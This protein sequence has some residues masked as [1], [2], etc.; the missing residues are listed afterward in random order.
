[1][2]EITK[3]IF[4]I[5]F[6]ADTFTSIQ[7]QITVLSLVKN[8]KRSFVLT[9]GNYW[10]C[11]KTHCLHSVDTS[12][13]I[14]YLAVGNFKSST[15]G[16]FYSLAQ[17]TAQKKKCDNLVS[18]WYA[19]YLIVFVIEPCLPKN[20]YSYPVFYKFNRY[21]KWN[22]KNLVSNIL[23]RTWTKAPSEAPK[24]HKKLLFYF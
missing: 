7:A 21:S 9:T 24:R 19:V 12:R 18:K 11:L 3:L 14:I 22:K 17:R 4:H 13:Q 2:Y 5:D 6:T 8:R 15:K 10:R 23:K 1:M 16:R 20:N